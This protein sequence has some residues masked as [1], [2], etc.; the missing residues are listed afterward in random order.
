M[1]GILNYDIERISMGNLN[2]LLTS[3]VISKDESITNTI[4]FPSELFVK[5]SEKRFSDKHLET[6]KLLTVPEAH[7]VRYYSPF[8]S[9]KYKGPMLILTK[10]LTS[11]RDGVGINSKHQG[12]QFVRVR[13]NP[14]A[15]KIQK[16]FIKDGVAL[17]ERPISIRII[18]LPNGKSRIEII[19]GRTRLDILWRLGF[20]NVIVDVFVCSD[21]DCVRH[22]RLLNNEALPFGEGSAEDTEKALNYLIEYSKSGTSKDGLSISC[23]WDSV[24]NEDRKQEARILIYEEADKLS[25]GTLKPQELDRVVGNVMK[26]HTGSRMCV[27]FP[28]GNKVEEYMKQELRIQSN[29]DIEYKCMV[30]L[31]VGIILE[32]MMNWKPQNKKQTLRIILYVGSPNPLKLEESWKKGTFEAKEAFD[33]F[34][35]NISKH[36]YNNSETNFSRVSLHGAIAQIDSLAGQYPLSELVVF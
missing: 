10:E 21:A 33:V 7:P 30:G 20:E 13:T 12:D 1:G 25:N 19:D 26:E 36:L 18:S 14:K 35:K 31:N 29:S 6:H 11:A 23:G 22:A 17:S 15:E 4:K 32:A 2:N 34:V 24:N 27:R 3:L 28:N 16:R 8:R 5:A 9:V